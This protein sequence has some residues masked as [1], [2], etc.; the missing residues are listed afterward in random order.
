MSSW[1]DANNREVGHGARNQ[2]GRPARYRGR[3]RRTWSVLAAVAVL[4]SGFGLAV[5][6]FMLALVG[7]T[8]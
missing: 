2:E 7:V 4:L 3:H 6:L 1:N 8:G 5:L